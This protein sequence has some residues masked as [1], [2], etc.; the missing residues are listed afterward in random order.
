MADDSSIVVL[1]LYPLLEDMPS[2]NNQKEKASEVG[3][4]GLNL[5]G[6]SSAEDS[7]RSQVQI[8]HVDHDLIVV[9]LRASIHDYFQLIGVNDYKQDC[10]E[11]TDIYNDGSAQLR[12]FDGVSI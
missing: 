2:G 9:I 1:E 7:D 12:L 4:A 5:Q 8:I 10:G 3:D 11:V 6:T